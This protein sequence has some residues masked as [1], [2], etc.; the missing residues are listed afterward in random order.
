MPSFFADNKKCAQ[1]RFRF[2][3]QSAQ[4]SNKTKKLQIKFQ[5]YF[6]FQCV[7]VFVM[8]GKKITKYE[9]VGSIH[10]NVDIDK[11]DV[12]KVVDLFLD[13]MKKALQEKSSI[14]LRGFGTFEPRLRKGRKSCRNPKTGEILSVKDRY[15]AV[16]RPGKELK[17]SMK[18][19]STENN[20]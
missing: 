11:A 12:L 17:M 9:I 8:E 3:K 1:K 10:S 6:L 13:E 20:D 4:V 15:T 16:F 5:F 7:K 14:E 2:E 19:L 18:N